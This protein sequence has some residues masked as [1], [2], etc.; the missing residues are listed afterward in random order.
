M[1][2]YVPI[3]KGIPEACSRTLD[4]AF[5]D[6][7]TAAAAERLGY[8]SDAAILKGRSVKGLK[9]LYHNGMMGHRKADGTF[10]EEPWE[11]WGDCFTEGSPWHHSFPPFDIPALTELYGGREQLLEKLRAVFKTP[12]NYQVGSYKVEIHEM[13]EMRMLGMG[14]YAHNNQPAHH[15]PYLF[16]ALGDTN[17][18]CKLV[19][20]ICSRAY[21]VDGFSGDEDN[22][23]MGAWFVLS[24]LGL[25]AVAVGVSEDYVLGAT[26]LFPR[27]WLRDLD[28][29]VE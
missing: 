28:V 24:A 14:Q 16:A 19:R 5:A 21:S 2:G 4:F 3:D 9:A 22:G 7:A 26:P 20:K 15:L 12:A 11:T 10:K 27:M 13:R 17:T 25:Y 29:I 6:A 1:G 18:T 23:E 8:A